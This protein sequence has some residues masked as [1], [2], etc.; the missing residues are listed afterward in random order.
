MRTHAH[1]HTLTVTNKPFSQLK[2]Q[3]C[4]VTASKQEVVEH[5]NER[6]AAAETRNSEPRK[7]ALKQTC[8]DSTTDL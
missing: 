8:H 3:D 4:E 5:R 7:A 6:S 2:G 1:T